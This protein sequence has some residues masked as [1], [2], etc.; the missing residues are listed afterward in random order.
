[1]YSEISRDDVPAGSFVYGQLASI[2][3]LDAPD[4]AWL[5][6]TD[7]AHFDE[8][9]TTSWRNVLCVHFIHRLESDARHAAEQLAPAHVT[10]L[11]RPA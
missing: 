7:C 5:V 9:S 2:E 4:D 1:M 6:A 8:G 10:T 11:V 3:A